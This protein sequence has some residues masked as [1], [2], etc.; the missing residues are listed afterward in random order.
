[1]NSRKLA[2]NVLDKL[3]SDSILKSRQHLEIG[4]TRTFIS[5]LRGPKLGFEL[6][7]KITG[8]VDKLLF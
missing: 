4:K 1:M 3:Q 2:K 7:N 8:H 5:V 6:I